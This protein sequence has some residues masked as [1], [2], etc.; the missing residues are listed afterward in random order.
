ME[1]LF[2][3]KLLCAVAVLLSIIYQVDCF[4]SGAPGAACSSLSP[5]PT[6]HGAPP[7][8]NSVPYNIDVSAFD[9]G[10]SLF[11]EPGNT[12]QITLRGNSGEMFRGFL[13]QGRQR[14]DD[15]TVLGSF[16]QIT[17]AT[18]RLGSCSPSAGSVTHNSASFKTSE[19]FTWTAPAAGSG[20]IWFGFAVVQVRVNYWANQRTAVIEE[21]VQVIDCGALP[22]PTNGQVVLPSTVLGSTATYSCNTGFDLVGASTRIC[23]ADSTWSGAEPSCQIVDCGALPNPTNGQVVLF[24]TVLG[25]TATYSCN[26]GFDLVGFATRFCQADSTWSGAEPSC[27]IIDCGV[28]PNPT[29]GQVVL[30]STVLGS[31]ATYSC[32][33]GFD[34]VGASTRICQADSTWSGAEPSCQIVDCGA[35][36]NPANGQ[37][38]LF[39]TVLGS[40][41]T[42]SCNTGF[43]LVGASTRICQAD[44]TW[45][46]AE[47]SCQIV[48]CGAL[49]NPANGQVVL[50]ST[51]LGSISTYSCNTGF[52]LVGAS[53]RICQ[54]DSTW[55]GAEPSCQIVAIVDCGALP[56][57]TNGQVVLFS[58]V[59]GSIA[60][61]SCNTGFDLVGASTRICQADSTWSGAEPSCQIVDCGALPNPA[62][63]Q[64]VL[65][66]TVLGSTATY[67]CNTGFDLV[68]FT[69]RFCQADSTWSGAEPSCQ[70]LEIAVELSSSVYFSEEGDSFVTITITKSAVTAMDIDVI[71]LLRDESALGGLDYGPF[72]DAEVS[73]THTLAATSTESQ[74]GIQIREDSIVEET[75]SFSVELMLPS[76]SQP[77]IVIGTINRATV[78]IE[79]NDRRIGLGDDPHYSILLPN[80][81]LLCYSVQGEHNFTFNLISNSILQMNALFVPDKVREEVTWIGGLGL[82]VKHSAYK[83]STVTRMRF[84]LEGKM[85]Y[86]GD[87]VKLSVKNVERISLSGGK[88]TVSEAD[89]DVQVPEVKVELKDVGLSFFVRYMSN[90]LDMIWDSVATQ[91]KDSHGMIGQFFRP[92][93]DIDEVRRMLVLPTLDPVPVMRRP[94]WAFMEREEKDDQLCWTAMNPGY[95]GKGL[96]EG[97]YFDYLVDDVLSSEF[98]F[99]P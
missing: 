96:L 89:S 8:T 98:K 97:H 16:T 27:Q 92:G 37:V 79:D 69:T 14:A 2:L 73:I 31:T 32:N 13:I 58:T 54:A 86:I 40:I 72:P 28:L 33:T 53:T 22:N 17:A 77:D 99:A 15:T 18:T 35:L 56:N 55:S 87:K 64:V 21:Q 71:I 26:T 45:S 57:P 47:P 82:V 4:S 1:E 68:G 10:G 74:F 59:L 5:D 42:Y 50:F 63:G 60:T 95:Q 48:D 41:A 49:P 24:S 81:Q 46:G 90:H 83:D 62:N 43:D 93:V 19:T 75:E 51:V 11:Y 61:Y 7:N 67:S 12:Y 65:F 76:A 84:A 88:L 85:L 29:N 25:S 66:S 20:S 39:S 44:S 36:P 3:V 91:P 23:Q 80:G 52:D 34:L 70:I 38:V 6:R 30:P 9:V 94:V 78:F